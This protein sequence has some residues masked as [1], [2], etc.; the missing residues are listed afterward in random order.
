MVA[1]QNQLLDD[2]VAEMQLKFPS[3][4]FIKVGVNLGT[5]GYLERIS[6]ATK[7]IDVQLIFNNAGFML[8]GFFDKQ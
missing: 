8:T 3:C 2:A 7:D 4:V 5:P 1:L 6:E